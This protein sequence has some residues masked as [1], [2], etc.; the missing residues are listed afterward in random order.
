L[1]AVYNCE[2]LSAPS[3]RPAPT[4]LAASQLRALTLNPAVATTKIGYRLVAATGWR[5]SVW[6]KL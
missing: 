3:G 6:V 1:K 5:K 4:R 2:E